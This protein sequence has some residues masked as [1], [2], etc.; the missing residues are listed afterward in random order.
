MIAFLIFGFLAQACTDHS[1]AK[2]TTVAWDE[3]YT[4]ACQQASEGSSSS[5]LQSLKQACAAGHPNPMDVVTDSCF[6]SLTDHPETRFELRNVLSQYAVQHQAQMSR[7]EEPGEVISISGQLVDQQT[8]AALPG[9]NLEL[10]HTDANGEYFEEEGSWN[11]R[12]FAYLKTAQDGSF[13]V[14]T[15]RPGA[16]SYDDGQY[17]PAHVHFTATIE[18]Y[19]SF[20]SEFVLGDDSVAQKMDT[21]DAL[22]AVQ[23]NDRSYPHFH[24]TIPLQ[25][26]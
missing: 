17:E 15:I 8:G 9:V 20:G 11:P 6:Y 3:L 23:R 25:P 19:R 18:G 12:I 7:P 10:I 14:Q 24:I 4:L 26:E 2:V 1:E 5:A 22:I 16:Y 21:E 13:E